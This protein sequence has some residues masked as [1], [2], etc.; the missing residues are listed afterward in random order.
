M[1]AKVLWPVIEPFKGQSSQMEDL[2]M[3]CTCWLLVSY[4]VNASSA[5]ISSFLPN[6]TVI[7]FG[8]LVNPVQLCGQDMLISPPTSSR[9]GVI[10]LEGI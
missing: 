1:S 4:T 8:Y 9:V 6:R 5:P 10:G 3:W 2:F 7:L